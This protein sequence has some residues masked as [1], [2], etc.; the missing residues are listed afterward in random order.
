MSLI[1]IGYRVAD[2]EYLNKENIV[3]YYVD[4]VQCKHNE[5]QLVAPAY[6]MLCTKNVSRQW[7]SK[8]GNI[9]LDHWK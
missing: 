3:V 7:S 6:I 9:Y 4:Y 2:D 1:A 5:Q 8:M